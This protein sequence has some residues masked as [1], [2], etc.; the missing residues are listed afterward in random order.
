M[1]AFRND[2]ADDLLKAS[3]QRSVKRDKLARTRGRFIGVI[4]I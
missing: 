4:V 1:R 2:V 3:A